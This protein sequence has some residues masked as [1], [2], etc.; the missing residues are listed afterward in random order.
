MYRS[1]PTQMQM[2]NLPSIP[3]RLGII[4]SFSMESGH[5]V[6]RSRQPLR[7]F[8][9]TLRHIRPT[10]QRHIRPKKPTPNP[11]SHSMDTPAPVASAPTTGVPTAKAT[12]T[13][14]P[15]AP[16]SNPTHK[17]TTP[18]PTQPGALA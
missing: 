14:V 3:Y 15:T 18:S 6:V 2:D 10:N 7:V 1:G 13:G 17:P 12:T 5:Q 4:N 9:L 11:T 16:T 8:L